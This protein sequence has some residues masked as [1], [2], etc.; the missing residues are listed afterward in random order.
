MGDGP[1]DKWTNYLDTS[2]IPGGPG[3]ILT[4]LTN[5]WAA[6]FGTYGVYPSVWLTVGT[7]VYFGGY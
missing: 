4:A 5:A 6:Y 7:V 3:A 2:T 1:P